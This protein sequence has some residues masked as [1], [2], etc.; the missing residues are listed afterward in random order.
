MAEF[1][2][3][4]V[5]YFFYDFVFYLKKKKLRK[6]SA[7]IDSPPPS[8]KWLYPILYYSLFVFLSVCSAVDIVSLNTC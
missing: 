3:A 6:V 5:D 7:T 8:I 2:M 1:D 4:P